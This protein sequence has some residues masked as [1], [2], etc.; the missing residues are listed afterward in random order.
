MSKTTVLIPFLRGSRTDW[1][2]EAIGSLPKGTPYLLLENDGEL[3]EALNAGLEA[4]KTEFVFRMDADDILAENSLPILESAAWDVDVAY[5]TLN[6]VS[7]TLIHMETRRAAAFC[8]HRLRVENYVAGTSL[9]RPEKA[10]EVGG[11][12]EMAALED[13][14]LWVRMMRAGHKFKGVP[15]AVLHYRQHPDSRNRRKGAEELQAI[16]D[17]ARDAI[18]PEPDLK[19]SFYYQASYPTT[20]W[21]CLLPA[22]HLPGQAIDHAKVQFLENDS[23]G[24]PEHRGPTA[25]WQ[26]PGDGGR[27]TMIAEMQQQGIRVLVE[28]DDSYLENSPMGSPGWV[29]KLKPTQKEI[30]R[31]NVRDG[32]H[33]LEAFTKI[34]PWV[35]GLTVTTE[36]LAK[37]YRKY[38]PNVFVCPN[39]ID[40]PDWPE[41]K[42]EPVPE[43][44]WEKDDGV[45]RIGWFA[46]PSHAADTKLVARALEWASEQ[47]D[48]LVVTMGLD[49]VWPFT[50][51][52]IPW[53][54]DMGVYRR[55]LGWLDVGL[56]PV[57]QTPWAACRSDLKALEMGVSG[58]APV[59]SD[60]IPYH[61]YKGPCLRAKDAREFLHHV[62]HLVKNR[63]EARQLAGAAREHVLMERTV[64]KNIHRWQE[65]VEP[66]TV[67]RAA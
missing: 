44:G 51:L 36:H 25:V 4:A 27:A 65:A 35:D 39:Q 22:R 20:Y 14:D 31:G 10:L 46:S 16:R 1:L 34:I 38:N 54:N 13:W 6:F 11:F 29:K 47:P 28:A 60:A 43:L 30:E 66:Q 19:A 41:P 33:S 37:R 15:E 12:R 23:L 32:V 56:A 24:F 53:S 50:R 67:K 61:G 49:P 58:V 17:G 3:A 42:S 59:L 63:D 9:F 64:E 57:V 26:F 55:M 45:F 21:R 48:V 62:K 40:P 7:E 18:G 5:P 8:P 2:T 52:H